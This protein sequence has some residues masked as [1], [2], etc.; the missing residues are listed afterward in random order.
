M[1]CACRRSRERQSARAQ[2]EGDPD[3]T[4]RQVAVHNV[5]ANGTEEALAL[6]EKETDPA[7]RCELYHGIAMGLLHLAKVETSTSWLIGSDWLMW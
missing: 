4:V 5:V 6:A 3:F 1:L 2:I 7:M